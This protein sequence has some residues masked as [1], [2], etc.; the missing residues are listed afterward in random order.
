MVFIVTKAA[1]AATIVGVGVTFG[2]LSYLARK[3][4]CS[5]F[6]NSYIFY[7]EIVLFINASMYVEVENQAKY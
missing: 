4:S 7:I 6:Y 2:A 3:I 5:K 1:L